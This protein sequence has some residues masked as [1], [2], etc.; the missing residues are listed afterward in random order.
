MSAN[1]MA[2]LTDEARRR[3]IQKK[4]QNASDKGHFSVTVD[5]CD[6]PESFAEELRAG[7]YFV[8]ES[9]RLVLGS[10]HSV[11]QIEWKRKDSN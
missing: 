11:F 8:H 7:G 5:A 2:N 6:M 4:M 1:E 3:M 9:K 10:P